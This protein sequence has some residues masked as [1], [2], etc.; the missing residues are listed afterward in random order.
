MTGQCE[1]H[2]LARPK[3]IGFGRHVQASPPWRAQ[4]GP[5]PASMVYADADD[6]FSMVL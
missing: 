6:R 2:V 3:R 5:M 1:R 4:P